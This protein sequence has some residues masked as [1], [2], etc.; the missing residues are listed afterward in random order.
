MKKKIMITIITTMIVTVLLIIAK[1]LIYGT[2][3]DYIADY[4]P[5][6]DDM[7]YFPILA[8]TTTMLRLFWFIVLNA[9][10]CIF[11]TVILFKKNIYTTEKDIIYTCFVFII[12]LIVCYFFIYSQLDYVW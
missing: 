3:T 6:A 10:F 2:E 11:Y 1:N 12:P 4:M 7:V 8:H 5:P 9:L